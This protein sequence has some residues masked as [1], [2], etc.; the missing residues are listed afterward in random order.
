MIISSLIIFGGFGLEKFYGTITLESW[1]MGWL[2][3]IIL[4]I[5]SR[6]VAHAY[7]STALGE[8]RVIIYGAGSAGIQLATALK[9]SQEMHPIAFIDKDKSLQNSYTKFSFVLS[10]IEQ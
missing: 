7:F 5:G 1:V 10:E 4:I 6:L 8:S 2:F 9:I 3:S